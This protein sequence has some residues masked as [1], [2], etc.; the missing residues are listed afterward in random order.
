M[1]TCPKP[2]QP[3]PDNTTIGYMVELDNL[4]K[5]AKALR[6][7]WAW[8]KLQQWK[9]ENGIG[10]AE[11]TKPGGA[12]N[13]ESPPCPSVADALNMSYTISNIPAVTTGSGPKDTVNMQESS[14][15]SARPKGFA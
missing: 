6:Q 2:S 5:I 1:S 7:V 12:T 11:C 9:K 8:I 4:F 13:A 15:S 3:W 10:N 14:E